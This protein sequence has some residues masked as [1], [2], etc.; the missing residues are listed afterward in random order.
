MMFEISVVKLASGVTL[1]ISP[2]TNMVPVPLIVKSPAP[3]M[4]LFKVKVP[5]LTVMKLFVLL[6]VM[7]IA[8][9]NA[10]VLLANNVPLFKV[11]TLLTKVTLLMLKVLLLF[12]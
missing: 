9:P 4:L 2:L 6:V 8:P 5:L 11:M 7:L 3:L 1:P 10:V 12:K